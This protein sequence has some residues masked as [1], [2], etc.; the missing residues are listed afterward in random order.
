MADEKTEDEE[1]V[2]VETINVGALSAWYQFGHKEEYKQLAPV[3]LNILKHMSK[4][5]LF[6]IIAREIHDYY[7]KD[8]QLTLRTILKKIPEEKAIQIYDDPLY[9]M[10]KWET[11]KEWLAPAAEKQSDRNP[12]YAELADYFGLTKNDMLSIYSSNSVL[13]M[14]TNL[15]LGIPYNHSIETLK[16]RYS[17][18]RVRTTE[19]FSYVQLATQ[20]I[21]Q[22]KILAFSKLEPI[23]TYQELYPSLPSPPEISYFKEK[24][25]LTEEEKKVEFTWDIAKKVFHS[26]Y[27]DP[28]TSILN[29]VNGERFMNQMKNEV[30]LGDLSYRYNIKVN[31]YAFYSL[32]YKY[33]KF[34]VENFARGENDI[35]ELKESAFSELIMLAGQKSVGHITNH[36]DYTL[37]ARLLFMKLS[38]EKIN[39]QSVFEETKIEQQ[40]IDKICKENGF[41]LG[42]IE[43]CE[44][45]TLMNHAMINSTDLLQSKFNFTRQEM[46][47]LFNVN[48]KGSIAYYLKEVK[49][50]AAKHYKCKSSNE[51]SVN[52]LAAIQWG[53]SGVTKTIADVYNSHLV[54]NTETLQDW[55]LASSLEPQEYYVFAKKNK[56]EQEEILIDKDPAL[57]I[58]TEVFNNQFEALL[59]AKY[60]KNY[61]EMEKRYKINH[62]YLLHIYLR[63][64][65]EKN[66]LGGAYTNRTARELAW[67]FY[68]QFLTSAVTSLFKLIAQN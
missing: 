49:K 59:F 3:M 56:R 37:Y 26:D 66:L 6:S 29:P 52:E 67:G 33:I 39:C 53:S 63:Y 5:L 46:T 20:Q 17:E 64:I 51:C 8:K 28:S 58:I 27:K 35:E 65:I 1:L 14:L 54:N 16:G 22:T 60:T 32:L 41:N 2:T 48:L 4:N 45:W 61:E 62:G 30:P 24:G 31:N 47:A 43:N 23:K 15:G 55:L 21:T 36:I 25:N 57:N 18:L 7:I 40:K 19:D 38:K 11:L 50:D 13:K 42:S 44:P 68:D 34:L 9:G 12:K 10:A